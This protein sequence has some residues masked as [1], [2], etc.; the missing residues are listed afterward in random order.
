MIMGV[1]LRL[2]QLY[3]AYGQ[4]D[5]QEIK[6]VFT[7][8]EIECLKK[9]NEHQIK[10]SEKTKNNY[11][12]KSVA[13][14]TYIIARLGGWKGNIKQRRAGPIILKRGL[15]KFVDIFEGW[16]LAQNYT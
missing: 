11:S 5:G 3:L 8:N 13:W 12:P 1:T 9:I 7:E 2:M 4:E 15:Q 10:T 16:K 14:A 6:E